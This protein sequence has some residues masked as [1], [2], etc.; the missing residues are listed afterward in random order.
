[1]KGESSACRAVLGPTYLNCQRRV[2]TTLC[3]SLAKVEDGEGKWSK[4][5]QNVV[6][7]TRRVVS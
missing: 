3:F 1:M 6:W 4:L 2:A 5:I 7:H